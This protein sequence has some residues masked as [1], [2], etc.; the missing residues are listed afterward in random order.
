M[1]HFWRINSLCHTFFREHCVV[2]IISNAGESEWRGGTEISSGGGPV[3]ILETLPPLATWVDLQP[4]AW[5]SLYSHSL[6]GTQGRPDPSQPSRHLHVMLNLV[7]HLQIL[8]TNLDDKQPRCRWCEARAWCPWAPGPGD[9]PS[10]RDFLISAT[11]SCW[12]S[13]PASCSLPSSSWVS[14]TWQR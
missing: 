6:G 10:T 13:P 3:V 8:F 12:L 1:E 9:Q 7:F 14:T 2:I 5:T 11:C 4:V